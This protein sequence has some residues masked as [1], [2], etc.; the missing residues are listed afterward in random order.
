MARFQGIPV[1]DEDERKPRF[2]GESITEAPLKTTSRLGGDGPEGFPTAARVAGAIG[3]FAVG[4]PLGSV[5]AAEIMGQIAD[6]LVDYVQGRE[7]TRRERGITAITN[8]GTDLAM[9]GAGAGI[10]KVTRTIANTTLR[11]W[12]RSGRAVQ[13]AQDLKTAGIAPE[14]AAIML[15][16]RTMQGT[17]ELERK[18]PISSNIFQKAIQKTSDDIGRYA[19]DVARS[20]GGHAKDAFR[21]GEIAREGVEGYAERLTLDAA[22]RYSSIAGLDTRTLNAVQIKAY[23]KEI[24]SEIAR[25]R[26]ATVP[27]WLDRIIKDTPDQVDFLTARTMRSQLAA[28][29]REMTEASPSRGAA[30][31]LVS[32]VD[33]AME[34]IGEQLDPKGLKDWRKANS[35]YKEGA[36]RL[37]RLADVRRG[38]TGIAAWNAAVG[39]T[40]RDPSKIVDLKKALK[41]DEWKEYV[42]ARVRDMGLETKAGGSS[43]I[44][45]FSAVRFRSAYRDLIP[46]VRDALFGKSGALKEGVERLARIGT[47]VDESRFVANPS[48]TAG[49]VLTGGAIGSAF[50]AAAYGHPLEAALGLATT[51]TAL[52]GSAKLLTNPAF[53][54]WL[55]DGLLIAQTN[56]RGMSVHLARL[57]GFAK[58]QPEM[59]GAVSDYLA[60]LSE[61]DARRAVSSVLTG[62]AA[63][64]TVGAQASKSPEQRFHE[65]LGTVRAQQVV[66]DRLPENDRKDWQKSMRK[67]A[68]I[69]NV[70]FGNAKQIARLDARLSIINGAENQTRHRS[71]R[72]ALMN[73]RKRL[74]SESMDMRDALYMAQRC[75]SAIH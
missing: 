71:E 61:T 17:I 19:E 16:S 6:H 20:G 10:S 75:P 57:A 37:D 44:K 39:G 25:G 7:R 30:K 1:E 34:A 64:E 5:P 48:G 43:E 13:I 50:T 41:P 63:G 59:R 47:A 35:I 74:A 55:G 31:R 8:V 54:R 3:G 58:V 23:A 68:A 29:A 28:Q 22:K 65:V 26:V 69:M 72:V 4:G 27:A 42:S 52:S 66:L 9:G 46:E 51:G 14:G 38:E 60:A 12:L 32:K 33:E 67:E 62:N 11:P 36:Q 70:F 40:N 18:L 49:H 45:E 73:A 2:Q 24:K 15:G 21:A 56:Y 53:V